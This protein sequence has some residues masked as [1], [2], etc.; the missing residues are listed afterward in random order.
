MASITS[1]EEIGEIKRRGVQRSQKLSTKVD[2]TPM[3]DLGFLLITFFIFTATI[4]VPTALNIYMPKDTVDD[5]NRTKVKESGALTILLGEGEQVFYYEGI[6]K[7][8][9]SN[10]RLTNSKGIR[11]VIMQKRKN[12][13][14]ECKAAMRSQAKEATEVNFSRAAC[15]KHFTVLIKPSRESAFKSTVDILDEMSI[16]MVKRFALVDISNAEEGFIS[17]LRKLN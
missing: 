16:N 9:G 15:D 12:V 6:L 5:S 17:T 13:I 10:F 11:N 8:D 3:V 1:N 4:T 7:E 14:A 2:M